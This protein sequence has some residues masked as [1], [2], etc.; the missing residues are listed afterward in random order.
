MRQEGLDKK[1]LQNT[2]AV[3]TLD[4]PTKAFEKALPNELWMSDAMHGITLKVEGGKNRKTYL[5]G[6]IDD[7]SRLIP[8]AQ[9]YFAED[10]AGLLDTLKHALLRRGIPQKFYTDNG[11]PFVSQHLQQVCARLGIQLLHAKPY[12]AYSKGKIERFFRTLQEQFEQSLHYDPVHNL[13]RLNRRLWQWLEQKYHNHPHQSLGE[14]SPR[15]RYLAQ[16]A[17]IRRIED[18]EQIEELFFKTITRRVRTDSTISIDKTLWEVDPI[19][20]GYKIQIHYNPH[21]SEP[22]LHISHNGQSYG[23]ATLCDKYLNSQFRSDQYD[24]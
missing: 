23:Q 24:F 15:E 13:E 5:F 6:I 10:T 14:Q 20:R 18:P 16:Q 9:Y 4:G 3:Q 21:A 7:H 8:H 1:T 11:K 22:V 12:A 2:L 19:L 17:H